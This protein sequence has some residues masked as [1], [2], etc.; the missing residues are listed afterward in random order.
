MGDENDRLAQTTLQVVKLMLEPL[1]DNR[2]DRPEGLVH[3]QD[4]WIGGK[5]AGHAGALLLA[6]GELGRVAR[7]HLGIQPDDLDQF[8]DALIDPRLIPSDKGRDGA[9]VLGDGAMGEQSDLL[10][11][12]AD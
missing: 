4:G 9:D 5:S 10:D 2:I 11:H 6:P 3:E 12:V 1:P 8:G 7:H